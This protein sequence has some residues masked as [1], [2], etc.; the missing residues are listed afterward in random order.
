MFH[1]GIFNM[2]ASG[3]SNLA[4][5]WGERKKSRLEVRR[6]SS[7]SGSYDRRDRLTGT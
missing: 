7:K 4:K 3:G 5:V 1:V 2:S 6:L